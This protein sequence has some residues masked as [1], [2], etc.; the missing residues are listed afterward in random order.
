MT[1]SGGCLA[2]VLGS[3]RAVGAGFAEVWALA[4]AGALA[5]GTGV[6]ARLGGFPRGLRGN[7]LDEDVVVV[8]DEVVVVFGVVESEVEE[9]V[10]ADGG[11]SRAAGVGPVEMLGPVSNE[12]DCAS[13]AIGCVR[14]LP[15]VRADAAAVRGVMCG[16]WWRRSVFLAAW[17]SGLSGFGQ[18]QLQDVWVCL[19]EVV[20]AAEEA[21]LDAG[22]VLCRDVRVVFGGSV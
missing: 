16:T 14:A 2:A 12:D 18:P 8:A 15:R 7:V 9:R 3:G 21:S 10:V 22:H 20:E 5:V 17:V 11:G 13:S 1:G 19:L 6:G 4:V